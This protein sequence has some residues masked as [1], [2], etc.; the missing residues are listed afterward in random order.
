MNVHLRL[1]FILTIGQGHSGTGTHQGWDTTWL[2]H[3]RAGPKWDWDTPWLGH[4]EIGPPPP[5]QSLNREGSW[6]T[7]DDFATSFLYFS[8]FS[9]APVSYTHLTLPTSDLV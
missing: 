4:N 5:R 6:G 1:G 3:N 7:T 9:T 8:L 2:G